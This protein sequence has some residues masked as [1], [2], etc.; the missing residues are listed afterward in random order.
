ME[1]IVLIN[2]VSDI[3][4]YQQADGFL[5]GHQDYAVYIDKSFSLKELKVLKK[6]LQNKKLY[7]LVNKLFYD[8]DLLRVKKYLE[9]LIL[10]N[11]DGIYFSDF[12]VYMLAQELNML[13]KLFFYHETFLR[14]SKDIETY[15]QLGINRIVISKD[16]HIDDI[17]SLT[18]NNYGI[19]VFGYFPIYYSKRRLLTSHAK[20]H[21]LI[22][23]TKTNDLM[24]KE[25]TRDEYHHILEKK[26]YSVI[27]SANVL[28]YIEEM[29]FLKNK[30]K[31]IIFN[32][33]F[34]DKNF[35][36]QVI[37]EFKKGNT[38]LNKIQTINNNL[39]INTGLL[40]ERIGDIHD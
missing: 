35:V 37:K 21:K 23:D 14:N 33:L 36:A 27:Y 22:I 3:N 39:T 18:N 40:H 5:C 7:V 32:S 20:K 6:K 10:L 38:T 28:C 29:N 13:D 11:V 9:Q 12:S 31:F 2:D 15:Q 1:Y 8:G 16:M 17:L 34:L 19:Q 24:I 25:V 4:T 30:F 26:D